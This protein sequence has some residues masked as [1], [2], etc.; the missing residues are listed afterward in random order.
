M[1]CGQPN[2]WIPKTFLIRVPVQLLTC[3][4]T[5]IREKTIW[6]LGWSAY[7]VGSAF[8]MIR[9]SVE[10]IVTRWESDRANPGI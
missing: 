5:T 8:D 2:V 9:T 10:R 6:A 4:R 3:R 1:G 7:S